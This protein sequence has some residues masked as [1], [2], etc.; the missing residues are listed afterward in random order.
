MQERI[1]LAGG[2]LKIESAQGK[3]TVVAI[4]LPLITP[5]TNALDFDFAPEPS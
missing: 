2:K 3:G 5:H 1:F 4:E